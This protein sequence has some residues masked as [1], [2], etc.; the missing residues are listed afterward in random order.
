MRRS[1][2]VLD[3]LDR[4]GLR[5]NTLV[6]FWSDHGYHLGEHGLWMKQS[7]FEESARVP[8]IIAPPAAKNAGKSVLAPSSCSTFIRRSPTSPG[9]RRQRICKAR[10]CVRCSRIRAPNGS[11]PRL[12][13]CNAAGSL[14]TASARNAGATRSGISAEKGAELYDHD[15]D[16]QE[17]HN[18][19][20][21][22]AQAATVAEMKALLK[23]V[24]PAPVAGGK[25]DPAFNAQ[26]GVRSN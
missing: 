1:G 4:L 17:L 18:L 21:E 13:R 8:L 16:P 14:G 11:V 12:R 26:L 19:A 23:T 2:R 24:H 3:A 6:V 20:A 10:A 7:C 22:S 5:E 25:A 9:S 15:A